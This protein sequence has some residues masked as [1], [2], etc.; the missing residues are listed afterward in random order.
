M[1]RLITDLLDLARLEA[2]HLAIHPAAVQV[3]TMLADAI[4]LVASVAADKSLRLE[5]DVSA[6]AERALGDRERILQVIGNLLGN[7][8]KFTPAGG[9]VAVRA[10]RTGDE[11]IVS[12]HDAGPGI[13]EEHLSRIFDRYWQAT[14]AAHRGTGLGLSIAKALVELHG[15]RIWVTSRPGAGSTFS[16]TLRAV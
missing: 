14:E 5:Q 10:Q 4:D 13:A 12:V 3:A 6:G 9:S 11:V 2:G 1:N 16:F 15:G 7:A 8:V